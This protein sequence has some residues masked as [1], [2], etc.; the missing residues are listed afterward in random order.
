MKSFKDYVE[1]YRKGFFQYFVYSLGYIFMNDY[2][3][4][5]ADISIAYLSQQAMQ[6]LEVTGHPNHAR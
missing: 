2:T 6:A 1:A 4:I 3:K 5:Y